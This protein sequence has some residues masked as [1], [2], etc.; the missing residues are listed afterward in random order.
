MGLHRNLTFTLPVF[1]GAHGAQRIS[2]SVRYKNLISPKLCLL[3]CAQSWSLEGWG[4]EIWQGLSQVQAPTVNETAKIT[5]S[6]FRNL[7]WALL[8]D[9]SWVPWSVLD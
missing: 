9:H 1:P 7:L 8:K 5:N 6:Q 4:L 3:V 2:K